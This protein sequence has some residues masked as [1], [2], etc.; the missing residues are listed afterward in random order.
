M[1]WVTRKPDQDRTGTRE[2]LTRR[3]G[4]RHH[5]SVK[6]P[7]GAALGSPARPGNRSGQP[8]GAT[9][10]V[11]VAP[12]DVEAPGEAEVLGDADGDA[13]VPAALTASS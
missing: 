2:R 4:Q 13:V 9:L 11:G 7:G 5:P 3:P 10:T 12:G 1:A 6:R 8:D